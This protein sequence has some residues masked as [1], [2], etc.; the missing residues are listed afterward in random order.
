F[1]YTSREQVP[2]VSKIVVNTTTKEA[3]Q[4]PKVLDQ[5]AQE[6]A[7]I[8]GQRP[9][10]TKARKSIATYKLRAGMPLGVKVTLRRD[11]MYDFLDKFVNI[12]LPRIR[13]FRGVSPKAFDGRGNF[14]VGVTEQLIFPEIDYNQVER[15]HGLN[16]SIITSAK[17]DAEGR[18]LLKHIGM[19]LRK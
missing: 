18:A 1:G 14:S 7:N 8:T 3:I 9:V 2:K 11:R 15:I 16:I 17:T 12:T 13:D 4:T 10:I 6:I 5:A 19:P